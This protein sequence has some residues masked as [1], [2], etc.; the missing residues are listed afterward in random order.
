MLQFTWIIAPPAKL[1]ETGRKKYLKVIQ[2][3]VF[4]LGQ[5]AN[6]LERKRVREMIDLY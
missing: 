2:L 5:I 4:S 6:I 3:V 1:R